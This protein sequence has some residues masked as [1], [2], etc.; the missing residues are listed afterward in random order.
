MMFVEPIGAS[1]TLLAFLKAG[2]LEMLNFPIFFLSGFF[3]LVP[4]PLLPDKAALII[5]P[6]SMGY[7]IYAPMGSFHSFVQ[8]C[9]NFG[10]IGTIGVWFLIG[11]GL[12]KLKFA[13]KSM[14]HRVSY[15]MISGFL[16]TTFFRDDFS[17]SI[18]KAILQL[19][20]LL[21]F[22]AAVSA[23][24]LQNYLHPPVPAGLSAPLPEAQAN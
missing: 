15:I 23:N 3:N 18:V 4:R 12:Q 24:M 16:L 1:Q 22:L 9:V 14:L 2:R 5:K 19:S 11:Y 8:F 21:P 6:E 10:L 7:K 13:D 17:G 20:I